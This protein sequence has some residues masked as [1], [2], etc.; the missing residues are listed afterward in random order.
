MSVGQALVTHSGP[1]MLAAKA[2]ALIEAEVSKGCLGTLRAHPVALEPA[3][4]QMTVPKELTTLKNRP[5]WIN[6]QPPAG[7]DLV[8]FRVRGSLSLP[9][10][11][12]A[13]ALPSIETAA[14]AIK[15]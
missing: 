4:T 12:T 8:R 5:G 3:Y 10:T 13:K 1:Y 14:G 15:C 2:R 11:Y 9:T 7:Q 6:E